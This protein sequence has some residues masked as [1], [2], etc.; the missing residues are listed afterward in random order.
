MTSI[1][2]PEKVGAVV[3]A[4]GLS[5]RMPGP[6]AKQFRLL[7][8]IP[9]LH[10]TLR[11]LAAERRVGSIVLV[12]PRSRVD[13]FGVPEGLG[14]SVRVVAGGGCR[15]DSV[16]KGVA[17]LPGEVDWVTV[18]DGA[19][20][21]LPPGLIEA[22]LSGALDCGASIAALPILDTV[23]RAGSG[24]FVVETLPR[25]G[26]WCAQTPQVARK[27][28]LERA[29]RL[30]DENHFQA[31]DEASLLEATGVRVKLI[32]G[33]RSNLKITTPG[34]LAWAESYLAHQ[35]MDGATFSVSE[36]TN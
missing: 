21:L 9:I 17:A 30:A 12:L 18:H 7:A 29:I 20:P 8:G 16:A 15:Q 14:V 1:P 3:P 31:T 11:R 36:G 33:T 34:D 26:L 19:R 22:C 25:G 6:V 10:H 2:L 13:S 5:E 32:L 24:G 27:D 35:D 28:L 4:A 23:K